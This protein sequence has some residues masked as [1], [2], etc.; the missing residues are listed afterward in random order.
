M[1][2]LSAVKLSRVFLGHD[3]ED[4]AKVGIALDGNVT[5]GEV[6][7][8]F[9]GHH[10][11]EWIINRVAIRRIQNPMRRWVWLSSLSALQ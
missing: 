7:E 6:L 1:N 10:F 3:A 2:S 4:G 8:F 9:R 11:F 5:I